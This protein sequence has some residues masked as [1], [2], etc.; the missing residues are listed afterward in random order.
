MS[1]GAGSL[2]IKVADLQDDRQAGDVLEM[3]RA[4]ACDPMGGGC[5]LDEDVR[6]RLINE[7]CDHPGIV[8]FLAYCDDQPVGIA[9]CIVSFSTFRARSLINIHD[10]SVLPEFRGRGVS[11]ALLEAVESYARER[12]FAAITLEVLEV[13]ERARKVYEAFGFS[14]VNPPP[15]EAKFFCRKVLR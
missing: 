11:R 14:D 4:Y 10:L 12:A 15:G 9:N 5:D 3:T 7:M 13:N 1:V 8:S 6:G 2:V